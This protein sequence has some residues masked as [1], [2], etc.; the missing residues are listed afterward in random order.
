MGELIES[1]SHLERAMK[2]RKEIVPDDN[3]N[4]EDLTDADW[5]KLVFF[6]DR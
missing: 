4:V 1:K 6:S 5:D 2:L 3:R